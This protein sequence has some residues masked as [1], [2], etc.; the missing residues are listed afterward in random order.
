MEFNTTIYET[1]YPAALPPGTMVRLDRARNKPEAVLLRVTHVRG[2]TRLLVVLKKDVQA[3]IA[4]ENLFRTIVTANVTKT[5]TVDK[6]TP[7]ARLAAERAMEAKSMERF[8][9]RDAKTGVDQ[10]GRFLTAK[11]GDKCIP[12]DEVIVQFSNGTFRCLLK[13]IDLDSWAMVVPPQ[14]KVSRRVS[15]DRILRKA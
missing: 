15:P 14:R 1:E 3:T 11:N 8:R 2:G 13:N 9:Q 10:T 6:G 7:D 5:G 4:G 12:G